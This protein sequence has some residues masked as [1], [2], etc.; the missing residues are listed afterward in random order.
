M[1]FI[2]T[3]TT[4]AALACSPSAYNALRGFGILQL[5]CTNSLK[6]YTSFNLEAPGIHE[7][8]ISYAREVYDSMVAE[9]KRKGQLVPLS[10]GVLIFDEVNYNYIPPSFPACKM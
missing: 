2:C 3:Y 7:E 5:P 1:L 9:K 8:R 10:E 6:S 4:I